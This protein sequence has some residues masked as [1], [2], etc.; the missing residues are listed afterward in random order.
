MNTRIQMTIF[1]YLLLALVPIWISCHQERVY[2]F[3]EEGVEISKIE[4]A[5]R[6]GYSMIEK[7]DRLYMAYYDSAHQ[8]TLAVFDLK[9]GQCDYDT[10]PSRIGWDSHN[11]VT[12][13]FDK[14][15]YLHVSGNMHAVPLVYFRSTEPYNIHTMKEIN[16]MT[17]LDEKR[18]TYPAFMESPD[19]ELVFHYRTGGSGN[20]SEIYNIYNVEEQSWKRLLDKPLTDGHGERNAYMQG[21]ILGK[22]GFYHL[23]WVWRETPDCST[24]HTLS[25]ARSRDLKHWENIAGKQTELPIT[26]EKT[27][28]YVDATPVKGGLFNP[29]IKLGFDSQ[30]R[31][32]IGYH[33]YDKDGNNQLY[34]AR[35]EKNGWYIK[36]L[37]DWKYRWQFEG[38]GSMKT[39]L[40]IFA[41]QALDNGKMAFGYRHIKEG[42][43][44]IVF[45][46]Q[47][48]EVLGKQEAKPTYP[49]K[50]NQLESSFPGM[51]P[52]VIVKGDYLLRWETLPANRDRKPKGTLPA[53]GRLM[54]YK[55]K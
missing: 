17:G 53:P 40:D 47:T 6:V 42:R 37:T 30:H 45:D 22:D 21:P 10:L 1:R 36:Q 35:Y 4:S 46:E 12:M 32:V 14:E 48:F 2:I 25:Y 20:G 38:N 13:A 8:M 26:L 34:V 52:H 50:Y 43:G 24:N 27:E 16:K 31:P 11:Y 41:P 44:E 49:E 28:F 23:I 3:P 39:E 55:W 51:Q 54:L 19:G 5:F 18:V 9:T 29:G 15:G 33:K 7:N